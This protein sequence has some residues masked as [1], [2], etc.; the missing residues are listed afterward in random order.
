MTIG[1]YSYVTSIS[2]DFADMFDLIAMD[3][4]SDLSNQRMQNGETI[5]RH[6]Y[7]NMLVIWINMFYCEKMS[8]TKEYPSYDEIIEFVQ[9]FRGDIWRMIFDKLADDDLTA[10]YYPHLHVETH[11]ELIQEAHDI[12]IRDIRNNYTIIDETYYKSETFMNYH[13]FV[14]RKMNDYFSDK[15]NWNHTIYDF[16]NNP[17]IISEYIMDYVTQ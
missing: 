16:M 4:L 17:S 6:Q 8:E 11:N 9:Q 7:I 15:C 10:E 14:E 3:E 13:N 12:F 2:D 5:Y 1:D